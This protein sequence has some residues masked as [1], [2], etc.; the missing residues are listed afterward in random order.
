MKQLLTLYLLFFSLNTWA[1]SALPLT[2]LNV[3]ASVVMPLFNNKPFSAYSQNTGS[4]V[5]VGANLYEGEIV[6]SAATFANKNLLLT[7]Y[8]S[9]LFSVGYAFNIPLTKN[10]W[11]KPHAAFGAHYMMFEQNSSN[12]NNLRES[13]LMYQLGLALQ[14]KLYKKLHLQVGSF[15][16]STQTYHKQHQ[17]FFQSGLMYYFNTPKN[18][19]YLIN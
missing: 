8:Q 7:E 2:K 5:Q 19:Q 4:Q 12:T 13:E 16:S 11:L 9:L 14:T 1:Q 18:I 6:L 10:L 15:Y 17:L 3:S